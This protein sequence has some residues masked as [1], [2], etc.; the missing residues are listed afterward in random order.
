MASVQG[1]HRRAGPASALAVSCSGR[2]GHRHDCRGPSQ[3]CRRESQGLVQGL[4]GT[5]SAAA[6]VASGGRD[7][8]V[9]LADLEFTDCGLALAQL[10][11]ELVK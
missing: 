9:D 10:G 8:I 3:L 11:R 5:A 6:A 2:H 1:R 4:A 7:I